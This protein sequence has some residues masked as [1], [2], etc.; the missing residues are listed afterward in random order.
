MRY[1]SFVDRIGGETSAAWDLHSEAVA[2]KAQGRDVVVLSIGDPD[3]NTPDAVMDRAVEAMR[4]GDT[5]YAAVNGREPLRRAIADQHSKITGQTFGPENVCVYAGAQNA[6][7][8]AT[9]CLV[10]HGDEVIVPEPCYV[11]YEATIKGPGADWVLVSQPAASGFRPDVDAIGRAVT[12]R[13][14]AIFIITPNNPTGV[15]MS[16]EELSAIGDIA[17]KND[18][19]VVSDEVYG[20]LTFDQPHIS[21]AGLPGMAERT[22]TISSLSKAYAMTGWRLGWAIGPEPLMDHMARLSLCMLYGMPGFIQEA[23]TTAITTCSSDV[24]FI[25]ETFR[26]RRDLLNARLAKIP[27]LSILSP[28]AGM[29]LM[30]DVRATGLSTAEFCRTLYDEAGVC[31]LDASPFGPSTDG[32]VRISFASSDEELTEAC[33]RI[34]EFIRKRNHTAA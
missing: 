20:E 15:M 33:V 24:E 1:S 5:H 12:N 7:Y 4:S 2:A 25:R 16:K 3:L 22:V 13:T 21:I 23:A 30:M 9:T 8:A 10:Q 14:K 18:L 6:L 19:W 28:E 32:Y 29:F 11:T 26:R 31:V 34:E 17:K 27:S